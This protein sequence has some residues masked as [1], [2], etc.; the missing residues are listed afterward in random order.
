MSEFLLIK[1][2]VSLRSVHCHLLHLSCWI[3]RTENGVGDKR[4]NMGLPSTNFLRLPRQKTMCFFIYK[5]EVK[6]EIWMNV[7]SVTIYSPFIVMMVCLY[8]YAL[9][10]VIFFWVWREF[11][12]R[13][14]YYNII[15]TSLLCLFSPQTLSY[16]PPFSPSKSWPLSLVK[17]PFPCSACIYV[18]LF[19]L[20][21]HAILEFPL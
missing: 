1:F 8:C 4:N 7:A 19:C 14:W 18:F 10:L 11:F 9:W 15:S 6:S 5:L 2:P 13:F 12:P 17:G 16:I 20:L 21:I 3:G